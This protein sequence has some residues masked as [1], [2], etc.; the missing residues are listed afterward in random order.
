M[1]RLPS[2]LTSHKEELPHR[3]TFHQPLETLRAS[4]GPDFRQADRGLSHFHLTV[5]ASLRLRHFLSYYASL[6][7][8]VRV[9][10]VR[11]LLDDKMPHALC[12][13]CG[14]QIERSSRIGPGT[15][16]PPAVSTGLHRSTR[17]LDLAPGHSPSLS[18]VDVCLGTPRG[19]KPASRLSICHP[20]K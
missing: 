7:Q 12:P 19:A 6:V 1:F 8:D 3:A 4:A 2:T 14:W 17:S 16:E 18:T 15:W 9:R 11:H 20:R 5:D 10:W 13:T